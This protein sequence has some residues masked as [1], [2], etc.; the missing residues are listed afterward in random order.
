MY[1]SKFAEQLMV[2]VIG[3]GF[4]R[5]HKY[6]E[7]IW[8]IPGV[9]QNLFL[10]CQFLDLSRWGRLSTCFSWSPG[11][12]SSRL[13]WSWPAPCCAGP[14]AQWST[15]ARPAATSPRPGSAQA[16]AVDN[17]YRVFHNYSPEILA[18]CFKIQR[19]EEK[20]KYRALNNN[21]QKKAK[22]P[23]V[24]KFRFLKLNLTIWLYL[25]NYP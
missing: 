10:L 16:P 19:P 23:S 2:M 12:A 4:K 13:R 11:A 22:S 21:S 24:S 3:Y 17:R 18:F 15:P 20:S 5:K 25:M 6:W 1:K 7:L 8:F 14:R 9:F